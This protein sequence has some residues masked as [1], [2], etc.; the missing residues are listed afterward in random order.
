MGNPDAAAALFRAFWERGIALAE[1]R[2]DALA[3]VPN[4]DQGAAR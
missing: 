2:R 3:A 1:E 4:T